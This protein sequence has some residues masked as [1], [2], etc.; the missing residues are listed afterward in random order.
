M[1]EK[2]LKTDGESVV[3]GEQVKDKEKKK[4][5]KMPLKEYEEELVKLQIELLKNL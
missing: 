5:D 3:S 2:K 1:E 4:K